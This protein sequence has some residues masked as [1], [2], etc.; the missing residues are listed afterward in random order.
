MSNTEANN[1]QSCGHSPAAWAE[2]GLILIQC[3]Q[4]TCASIAIIGGH[5]FE[6][7]TKAWDAFQSTNK[8]KRELRETNRALLE[9]LDE[10][11]AKATGFA[12]E[13]A[14]AHA[15]INAADKQILE[16]TGEIERLGQALEASNA[17]RDRMAQ[18]LA[19]AQSEARGLRAELQRLSAP[20]GGVM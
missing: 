8:D 6:M 10:E 15:A 5:T 13:I 14:G 9:Q 19:L 3:I 17:D 4:P 12:L 2:G 18:Q 20:N 11:R 16:L 7:A 1:C